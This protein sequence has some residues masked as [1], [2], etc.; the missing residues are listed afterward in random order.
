MFTII[1]S[2]V[3]SLVFAAIV[4]VRLGPKIAHWLVQQYKLAYAAGYR[5]G[6]KFAAGRFEKNLRSFT[7]LR[8]E[9]RPMGLFSEVRMEFF[10][11]VTLVGHRVK[12]LVGDISNIEKFKIP[13]Y[14]LIAIRLA[15]ALGGISAGDQILF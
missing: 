9:V 13:E 5:A 8:H 10:L 7:F 15:V 2:V 11:T 14:I 12:Y 4:M 3:C 1:A 6:C